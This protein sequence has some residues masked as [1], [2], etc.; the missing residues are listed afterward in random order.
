MSSTNS[1]PP[2]PSSV[3]DLRTRVV[4]ARTAPPT[5]LVILFHGFGAD[6]TDLEPVARALGAGLP[7]VEW[8]LPDGIEPAPGGH[9]RQW[10]SL[11][12][13]TPENRT[14]RVRA[15]ASRLDSFVDAELRRRGLSQDKLILAGFSQGAILAAWLST[16]RPVA[17]AATL[18][19]SGR[20]AEDGE[21]STL[22]F[23]V[24]VGH[25]ARDPVRPPSEAE[26]SARRF[27]AR[28]AKVT[29]RIYPM[30][31]HGIGPDELRD[32]E[33]F[34]GAVVGAK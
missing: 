33:A 19:L 13:I 18:M 14:E 8:V 30:L 23:P 12:Q 28:G 20:Y 7:R 21:K 29:K 4:P 2:S 11:A 9:G 3:P 1:S 27:E 32:V 15:A 5:H 6:C 31:E 24:F 17:P 25:G 16:H 22:S 10:F 34:L 26:T